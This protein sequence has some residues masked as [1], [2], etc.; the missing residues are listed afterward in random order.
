MPNG[1]RVTLGR[2]LRVEGPGP[3]VFVYDK[4][5]TGYRIQVRTHTLVAV[6]GSSAR[7]RGLQSHL[8]A[9]HLSHHLRKARVPL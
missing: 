3:H 9:Q 7:R 8:I 5:G 1:N 4:V 2:E 6:I